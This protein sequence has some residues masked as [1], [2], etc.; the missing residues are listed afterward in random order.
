[1]LTAQEKEAERRWANVSDQTSRYRGDQTIDEEW[2]R[3]QDPVW[4]Q[5][6]DNNREMEEDLRKYMT[7]IEKK[8][9][10]V[11]EQLGWK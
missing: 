9:S 8:I 6:T 4:A 10:T 1:M 2:M 11:K 5:L 3:E 7:A